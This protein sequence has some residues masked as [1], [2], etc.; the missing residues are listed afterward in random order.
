MAVDF[1]ELKSLINNQGLS[2]DKYTTA[3]VLAERLLRNYGVSREDC[4]Y[5]TMH[6]LLAAHFLFLHSNEGREITSKSVGDVSISY[7][8]PPSRNQPG[9][10]PFLETFLGL[11]K[12]SD[13][14]VSI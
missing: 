3:T 11:L 2:E 4:D 6:L 9:W 14:I 1:D 12:S 5:D 10:S 13:F 7:A 8:S